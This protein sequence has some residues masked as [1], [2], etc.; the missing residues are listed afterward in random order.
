[1]HHDL[2]S[3]FRDALPAPLYFRIAHMSEDAS[4]PVHTHEWGEFV[5][6]FQG[7]LEIVLEKQKFLV[8]PQYGVWLPPGKAHQGISKHAATHSSLYVS[9]PLCAAF[10]AD[11][12][13]LL[14][15][16]FMRSILEYLRGIDC[17]PQDERYARVLLVF[18]DQLATAP[19][20][21]SYLP[22]S[23]DPALNRLLM[24]LEQ[25]PGD[26]RTVEALAHSINLTER[27]LARR[28]RKDL[29]MPLVE[30]RNRLRVLKALQML[31]AGKSVESIA[32]D[33][34]YA[35]ASSF[36]TMFKKLTGT[37]PTGYG[38]DGEWP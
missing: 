6:S 18:L 28:C 3:P 10:P 4:Y 17:H 29:G 22:S 19:I 37:T 34:G 38:V 24:Q 31:A 7:V 21:G 8:P 25:N 14:I 27:T 30:W 2:H 36:I 16:P 26:E 20:A 32:L 23:D 12:Q 35:N 1:M 5:Y 9:K 15:S 33:F 11:A 13:A